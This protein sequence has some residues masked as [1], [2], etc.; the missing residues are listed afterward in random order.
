MLRFTP[1]TVAAV[2]SVGGTTPLETGITPMPPL[3]FTSESSA[4]AT[5]A[6]SARKNAKAHRFVMSPLLCRFVDLP[7]RCAASSRETIAPTSEQVGAAR[8]GLAA[9]RVAMRVVE[10]TKEQT[11]L[12]PNGS[13]PTGLAMPR[14]RSSTVVQRCEHPPGVEA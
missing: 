3:N 4:A 7:H 8:A 10:R 1:S 5:G 9:A 6:A 12:F 2:G 13:M 14:L 11:H